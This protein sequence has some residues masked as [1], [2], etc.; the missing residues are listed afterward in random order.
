M[1]PCHTCLVVQCVQHQG[2]THK[3]IRGVAAE[4]IPELPDVCEHLF[5]ATLE[6]EVCHCAL[7][8]VPGWQQAER[9][10]TWLHL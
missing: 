6:Q 1:C 7:V 10:I 2:N 9:G 4:I 8:D 3:V 5:R